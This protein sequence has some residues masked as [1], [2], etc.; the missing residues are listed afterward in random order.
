MRMIFDIFLPNTHHDAH[1][2]QPLRYSLVVSIHIPHQGVDTLLIL[3]AF[4][5][6]QVELEFAGEVLLLVIVLI[7]RVY[8]KCP[9]A[10]DK[11]VGMTVH[12]PY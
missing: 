8:S 5:L 10:V 7:L 1:F 9:N 4:V 12:L 3:F 6:E 2:L 11:V